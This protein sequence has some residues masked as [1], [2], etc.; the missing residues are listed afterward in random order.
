MDFVIGF[1]NGLCD[2]ICEWI[3]CSHLSRNL[4]S[5]QFSANCRDL[6]WMEQCRQICH[7]SREYSI[8]H[9]SAEMCNK[10]AFSRSTFWTLYCLVVI[11]SKQENGEQDVT[12]TRPLESRM[13]CYKV[14]QGGV[15]LL[16]SGSLFQFA[17]TTFPMD[18]TSR[19]Q[20]GWTCFWSIRVRTDLIPSN[21]NWKV[22]RKESRYE[23]ANLS[24]CRC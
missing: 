3:L 2:W 15:C 8:S 18:S 4:A 5:L 9:L 6:L 10:N 13:A 20:L 21:D 16:P 22:R 23:E 11:S 24:V 19:L 1:V 7:Q 12:V 17:H 14:A